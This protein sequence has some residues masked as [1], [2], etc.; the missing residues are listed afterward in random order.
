MAPE[1]NAPRDLFMDTS[2]AGYWTRAK[3]GNWFV[4]DYGHTYTLVAEFDRDEGVVKTRAVVVGPGGTRRDIE[5]QQT[6]AMV[7]EMLW[8]EGAER[9]IAAP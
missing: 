6:T 9:P 3:S 1:R 8:P 7:L 5:A 4:R 2:G